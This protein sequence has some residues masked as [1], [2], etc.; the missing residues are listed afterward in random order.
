[1]ILL[2]IIVIGLSIFEVK[3]MW[4]KKQKKEMIVYMVLVFITI[5]FGWFYISNPYAPSFS[6]MVLKLLG[7]EV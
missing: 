4:R 1:M 3:G 6:V 2:S 5:T 7:F